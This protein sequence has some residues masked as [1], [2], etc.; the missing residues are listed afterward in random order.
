[1]A[2]TRLRVRPRQARS[3]RAFELKK[4]RVYDL[5]ASY[6]GPTTVMTFEFE[7][8]IPETPRIPGVP[9]TGQ[10]EEQIAD[11]LEAAIALNLIDEEP[12]RYTIE[13]DPASSIDNYRVTLTTTGDP[14]EETSGSVVP[15]SMVGRPFHQY[16]QFVGVVVVVAIALALVI[17]SVLVIYSMFKGQSIVETLF[18]MDPMILLGG[19]VVIMG[20]IL[21]LKR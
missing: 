19:A 8:F 15:S 18:G 14:E 2:V 4:E 7:A 21:L 16:P 12:L 9:L 13:Q 10:A 5:A 1:M 3:P 11:V 20:G 6:K 17:F